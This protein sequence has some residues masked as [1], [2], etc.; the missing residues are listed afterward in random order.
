MKLSLMGRK[1]ISYSMSSRITW[2]TQWNSLEKVAVGVNRDITY[3]PSS[4]EV[5]GSVP[6]CDQLVIEAC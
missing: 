4:Y 3:L 6:L 5:I 2:A 1:I